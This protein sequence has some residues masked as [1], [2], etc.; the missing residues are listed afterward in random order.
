VIT[1]NEEAKK[2]TIAI[3]NFKG[4][5]CLKVPPPLYKRSDDKLRPAKSGSTLEMARRF[6]RRPTTEEP[7]AQAETPAL[8]PTV[9]TKPS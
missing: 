4:S 1:V 3:L 2:K 6:L 8:S 5:A 9:K 7:P